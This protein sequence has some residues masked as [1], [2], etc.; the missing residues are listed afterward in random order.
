MTDRLLKTREVMEMLG[1]ARSTIY[2]K[3][4]IGDF[5]TPI[6]LGVRD[7]RWRKAEIE[8]W[9]ANKESHM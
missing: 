1:V 2:E 7:N 4:R 8:A 3:M 6:K 9:L 5:P